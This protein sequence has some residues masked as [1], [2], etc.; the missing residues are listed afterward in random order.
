MNIHFHSSVLF[1]RD[2]EKAKDF[3]IGL[4]GQVIEHDFGKNVILKG[5]LTLWEIRPEHTIAKELQISGTTNR[6]ELYFKTRELEKAFCK[7]E[8]E[9]VSFLHKI[10][11]EPWGQRTIRFFD[12]DRH[13]IEIG[14]P[15][16]VFVRNMFDKGMTAAHI[17]A[18]GG[19]P[20]GT[21]NLL[22]RK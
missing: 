12:P 15:L 20:L 16:E 11:E 5:G 6:L 8:K 19:I 2:I 7:L 14:E 18:K 21:I 10:H 17:S 3:Y 9:G 1:V 4:L 22:L 13:L